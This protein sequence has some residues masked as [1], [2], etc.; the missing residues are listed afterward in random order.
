MIP[1]A[2]LVETMIQPT[3]MGEQPTL[4]S[5][6]DPKKCSRGNIPI[7]RKSSHTMFS[8]YSRPGFWRHFSSIWREQ[9]GHGESTECPPTAFYPLCRSKAAVDVGWIEGCFDK[10]VSS[11]VY[12]RR[13]GL[14]QVTFLKVGWVKISQFLPRGLTQ[15][16]LG[17]TEPTSWCAPGSLGWLWDWNFGS[18]PEISLRGL[19]TSHAY[20]E[21]FAFHNFF[22]L[23]MGHRTPQLGTDTYCKIHALCKIFA[24]HKIVVLRV[25]F[26]SFPFFFSVFFWGC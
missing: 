15:G 22:A 19:Y 17:K 2:Q 26:L 12:W 24:L 14:S 4:H 7:F 8:S 13:T 3:Y 6:H 23:H 10:G 25:F 18:G 5:L 9:L 20:S 11:F 21:F 16:E 1:Y